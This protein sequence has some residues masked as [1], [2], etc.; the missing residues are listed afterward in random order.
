MGAGTSA[1]GTYTNFDGNVLKVHVTPVGPGLEGLKVDRIVSYNGLEPQPG[2]QPRIQEELGKIDVSATDLLFRASEGIGAVS[3]LAANAVST[4]GNGVFTPPYPPN[5]FD[6]PTLV[7]SILT[8]AEFFRYPTGFASMAFN[9]LASQTFHANPILSGLSSGVGTAIGLSSIKG[10]IQSFA[11]ALDRGDLLTALQSGANITNAALSTYKSAL[12]VEY[13]A[14]ANAG[15]HDIAGKNPIDPQLSAIDSVLNGLGEY[16]PILNMLASAKNGSFAQVFSALADLAA[17]SVA[18]AY[19]GAST[20]AVGSLFSLATAVVFLLDGFTSQPVANAHFENADPKTVALVITFEDYGGADIVISTTR[21]LLE[22]L[23]G[24]VGPS[25][26]IMAS[27]KCRQRKVGKKRL[28]ATSKRVAARGS[29]A[30]AFRQNHAK[31]SSQ[32]TA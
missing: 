27:R 24:Q 28:K 14:V 30:A 19:P 3:Q 29:S 4:D 15:V 18:A 1:D 11:D 5:I 8:A 26:G 20:L 17:P 13:R 25:Q 12:M 16:L 7:R 10:S 31:S 23:K 32:T 21:Q 2:L 6:E 9:D 22:Q